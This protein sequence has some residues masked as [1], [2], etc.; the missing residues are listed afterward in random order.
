M[1]DFFKKGKTDQFIDIG[2][3]DYQTE[4]TFVQVVA[5][6]AFDKKGKLQRIQSFFAEKK[7]QYKLY[8]TT[9]IWDAA[10]FV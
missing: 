5:N 1:I 7:I 4:G 10:R 6:S 9:G 3:V 2:E 8:E